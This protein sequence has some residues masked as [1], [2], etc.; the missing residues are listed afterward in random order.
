MCQNAHKGAQGVRDRGM[1]H[2]RSVNI[3]KRLLLD[4]SIGGP[5][6][7]HGRRQHMDQTVQVCM[8]GDGKMEMGEGGDGIKMGTM[9]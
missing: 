5:S 6:F 7:V 3:Q 9:I 4:Q 1:D 2:F 8:W